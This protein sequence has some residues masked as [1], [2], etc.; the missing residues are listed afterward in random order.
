MEVSFGV[1]QRQPAAVNE[2]VSSTI[3]LESYLS[4][5]PSKS[6]SV[7]SHVTPEEDTAVGNVQPVQEGLLRTMQK[8]VERV[9]KLEMMMPPQWRDFNPQPPHRGRGKPWNPGGPIV[10]DRPIMLI[11]L[12]IMLC[13]SAHFFD[14]LCSILC[15][16]KRIVLKI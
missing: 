7:V 1:K 14:L 9:E 8:L 15:S 3:E 13:C 6:N 5:A 12:P 16:C 4:K 11:F 2:A 10:R